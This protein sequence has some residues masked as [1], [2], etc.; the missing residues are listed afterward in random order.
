MLT[1]F[2]SSHSRIE[3]LKLFMLNPK[4]RYYPRQIESI[5]K[6]PY[7]AVRRQLDNFEKAGLLKVDAEANRKYYS[8]NS[9]FTLLNE[10]KSIILK[11]VGI[12]DKIK[13]K[14]IREKE[15]EIAF[16]YGSYA[17]N[18]ENI[19]SDIDVFI[20]GE[21]KAKRLQNIIACLQEEIGREI[22]QVVY[23][24]K[25]FIE[26]LNK[27]N[28]FINSVINSPKIFIKGEENDLRKLSKDR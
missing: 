10:L 28:H 19:S 17:K 21:I 22:N 11:T 15:I 6:I 8:V 16:I 14:L 12:G 1:N 25:E 27:K 13:G 23:S 2:F 5:L 3:V 4:N 9:R 20:I 18:N 26:K 7:T 24:K